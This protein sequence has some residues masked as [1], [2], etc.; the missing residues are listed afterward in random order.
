MKPYLKIQRDSM[1]FFYISF[2]YFRC[3]WLLYCETQVEVSPII[4][5]FFQDKLEN[6]GY[7]VIP[8]NISDKTLCNFYP[9]IRSEWVV[10]LLIIFWI[11]IS[12]Y[13]FFIFILKVNNKLLFL[14]IYCLLPFIGFFLSLYQKWILYFFAKNKFL[15]F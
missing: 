6:F 7:C 8:N 14:I 3:P 11:L 2:W 4:E 13:V 9:Y 1:I 15:I 5:V 12:I 10:L